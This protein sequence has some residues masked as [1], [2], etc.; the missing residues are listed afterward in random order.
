MSVPGI[1]ERREEDKSTVK[2]RTFVLFRSI[3]KFSDSAPG[4]NPEEDKG[5]V[6]YRT[7]VLFSPFYNSG[8]HCIHIYP[9]L[10]NSIHIY[11]YNIYIY[12]SF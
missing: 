2:Y 4:S 6:F 10:S 7:F 1:I 8:T 9:Y 11:L 12:L 5:T 3:I